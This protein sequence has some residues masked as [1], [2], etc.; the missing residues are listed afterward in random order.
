MRGVLVPVL[1][2]ILGLSACAGAPAETPMV[3]PACGH[4]DTF[5]VADWGAANPE[6]SGWDLDALARA[7]AAFEGQDSA[8]VMVI[9][10]G[11]LVAA[12]GDVAARYTAQSV[13]KALLN[14]LVGQLVG[15]G[16]VGLDQTLA[17]LGIDDV[18]PPLTEAEKQATVRDLLMS[19]SGIFHSAL[20]EVGGWKKLREQMAADELAAGADVYPHGATWIYN[21]WDFNALGTIVEQ[22]AGEEIGPL[23]ARRIAAP[24]GMQDF[25]P[26]DVA[27]TT[28]DQM[29]EKRFG[30]VSR[31]RAYVFDISTRDLARYG[32]LYLNCGQWGGQQIVPRDWVLASIVGPDTNK[33]WP[34]RLRPTG[35]GEYGYLWQIDRPGARRFSTLHTR[36]PSYFATGNRGHVLGV[37]PSLDLVIAHQVATVG[38][39]SDAAQM[40]R[41][42]EGSPEVAEDQIAAL[43]EAIIKA[44]PDA[45][46]AFEISAGD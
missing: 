16:R 17:E 31:H 40:K 13:R 19:R 42:V 32:L 8:A 39:V 35:F 7:R 46:T 6:Q 1:A 37:F 23:F 12:W 43:F 15:E 27:Y 20:Y 2:G 5:P 3:W 41:A 18:S 24:T 34:V 30:N 26:G 11:K 21:N 29:A 14:S 25:H 38:G 9:H 28:A 36:A 4:V 10:R 44:H 45:A 33:G 22:V